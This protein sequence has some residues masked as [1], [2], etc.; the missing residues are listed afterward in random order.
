MSGVDE[1]LMDL[2]VTLAATIDELAALMT[3]TSANSLTFSKAS[4]RNSRSSVPMIGVR[5]WR[6]SRR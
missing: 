5:L 4:L 1:V 2:V 3:D 6:M